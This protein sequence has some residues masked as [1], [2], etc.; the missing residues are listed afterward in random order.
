MPKAKSPRASTA[1]DYMALG[2]SAAQ[3]AKY[4]GK[5]VV[6]VEPVR[7]SH[8]LNPETGRW[9]KVGGPTHSKLVAAG[10]L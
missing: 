2:L 3:A 7:K 8:V 6:R 10:V 9:V 1:A 4:A 5:G